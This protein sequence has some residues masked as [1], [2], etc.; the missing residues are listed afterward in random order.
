MTLIELLRLRDPDIKMPDKPL[1]VLGIDLGTTNSTIAEVI[2][3]PSVPDSAE[4]RCLDVQQGTLHG[5]VS[6]AIVPSVIAIMP[7]AQMFVGEG[8]KRVRARAREFELKR[9]EDVFYEVK[10][11]MGTRRTYPKAPFDMQTPS[12]VSS[13]L[14]RFLLDSSQRDGAPPTSRTVV[15]VPASYQIPQRNDARNAAKAAG[16]EAGPGDLLDE[17]IAAFLDFL[18]CADVT[19]R[20]D[21]SR[22]SNVIVF[23]FGGGTCDI[24][25]LRLSPAR[26]GSPPAVASSA[27]SRYQRLGG[28]D[29]DRAVLYEVLLPQLMKQNGLAPHSLSYQQ[30]KRYIEPA[31]LSLA[32]ALKIGI[33]A[34]VGR[35]RGLGRYEGMNPADVSTTQPGVHTCLL[36]DEE[37][38]I[39][40]P[41]LNAAEFA[42]LLKPFLDRELVYARD[43]EY[44]HTASIFSPIQ[45]ALDMSG[46]ES[47][48][49][50]YCLAVGGSSLIPH[51]QDELADFFSEAAVLTYTDY[52]SLQ[53]A[54]ARGAACHAFS[55]ALTG[56]G[57]IQPVCH[58]SIA[59]MTQAGPMELVK[60]GTP[61]PFPAEGY[62]KNERLAVPATSGPEEFPLRV[63]V[64]GGA[65]NRRLFVQPWQMTGPVNRDDQL[66]L[67]YRLD[68]NQV[69][70]MRITHPTARWVRAFEAAMENPLTN[71]VNP[72]RILLEAEEL[73]EDIR[74]GVIPPSKQP[75][76]LRDLAGKYG[77]L[78]Q[79]ERAVALYLEA[80][81]R[82]ANPDAGLLNAIGMVYAEMG[83]VDK[84]E[85]F[86]R[87][88][89]AVSK[90]QG[91]L[92]NLALLFDRVGRYDDALTAVD[93]VLDAEKDPPYLVLK[94]RLVGRRGDADSQRKLLDEAMSSFG[95]VPTLNDWELGWCA[96]GAQMSGRTRLHAEATEELRRRGRAKTNTGEM[97]CGQLPDMKPE[98]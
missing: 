61:L 28:G 39:E 51:V 43:T 24:A 93:D 37:L 22:P 25:L 80:L 82:T 31:L 73:E 32:E 64:V 14:L 47:S 50:D 42:E 27:V 92:F 23:D 41:T 36:K 56:R 71:I 8:A 95:P 79:N 10:N 94:A 70:W 89:A 77:E 69:L 67:H 74:A 62:A 40:S 3:D 48:E 29:I 11:E 55:L 78:N 6:S 68:T 20:L 91:S 65:D 18:V 4:P 81:R 88:A 38:R 16:I 60:A 13:K 98:E 85:K 33:C 86:Y 9:N 59:M 1:R 63:E 30:K 72:N 97:A 26:R 46:L 53:T 2:W 76:A 19:G 52:E 12:A 84:A 90:W 45:D 21:L 5:T 17:P 35:L 87:E 58:E 57:L 83:D 44:R 34:E 15:T 49:V 75:G 96:S 7:D 54:V 66:I